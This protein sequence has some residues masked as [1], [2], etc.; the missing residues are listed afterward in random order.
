[1]HLPPNGHV[2]VA[3]AGHGGVFEIARPTKQIAG[4]RAAD[5]G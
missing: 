3:E 5:P 4:K 2:L 1:L